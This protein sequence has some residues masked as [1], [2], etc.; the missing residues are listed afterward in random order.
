MSGKSAGGGSGKSSGGVTSISDELIEA[1]AAQSP[2][3]PEIKTYEITAP[4]GN[5][6]SVT[7][8]HDLGVPEYMVQIVHKSSGDNIIL[9]FTRSENDVIFYFGKV[10][11][12]TDYTVIIVQ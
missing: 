8:T 6:I 5:D 12:D 7:L 2:I 11:T 10:Q 1:I 4:T 9:P 3:L